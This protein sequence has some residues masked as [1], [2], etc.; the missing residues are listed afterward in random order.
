MPDGLFKQLL[1]RANTPLVSESVTKPA[2]DYLTEP[3]LDQ[4]PT[5]ARIKGFFG[6]ALEGARG[7]TSPAMLAGM[8]VDDIPIGLGVKAATKLPGM[9][10]KAAR[11]VAMMA[12][13]AAQ[14]ASAAASDIL[15]PRTAS[16]M[17]KMYQAAKPTYDSMKA[18][19]AGDRTVGGLWTNSLRAGARNPEFTAVGEEGLYNAGRELPKVVDPVESAYNRILGTPVGAGVNALGR[20]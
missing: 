5:M 20:K 9:L 6:G 14:A 11:P 19:F 12:P 2:T 7:L 1:A 16:T 15:N 13:E 17:E 3:H 8:M 10:G 18:G 4:S